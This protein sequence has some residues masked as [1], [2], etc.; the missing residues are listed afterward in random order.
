VDSFG[1]FGIRMAI[2]MIRTG[3]RD[4]AGLAD[5]MMRR[6]G[7][8]E[9]H[10]VLDMHFAQRHPQFK[11]HTAMVAVRRLLQSRPVRGSATVLD[12]VE[13]YLSDVHAFAESQ[14]LGKVRAK[15]IRLN[16]DAQQQLE[17][18]IGGSGPD[19]ASRLGLDDETP[20]I[21]QMKTSALADLQ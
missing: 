1:V 5:E 12:R 18:L 10:R 20:T 13:E 7:L 14:L 3:I 2:A 8:A 6:S 15:Q 16:P 19:P 21:Q 4:T 9:L 17:R 11:A